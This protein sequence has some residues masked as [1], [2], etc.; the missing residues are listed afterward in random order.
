MSAGALKASSGYE[1]RPEGMSLPCMRIAYTEEDGGR[2]EW[3]HE[4]LA[5]IAWLEE[6]FPD[7]GGDWTGNIM[8]TTPLQRARTAE[9]L[10]LIAEA[11][12]YSNIALIHSNP[13]T[14]SWSGLTAAEM[15]PSAAAAASRRFHA[16]LAKFESWVEGD[17]LRGG[18]RSLSGEGAKV[19]VADVVLMCN[20][21]YM[22][23]SYGMDWVEEHGVLRVWVE[24]VKGEEG[25]GWFVGVG[26]LREA[27]GRGLGGVLGE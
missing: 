14:L 23:E 22:E 1:E 5:I 21:A 10:S 9:I 24:R 12:V 4:S 19:T 13:S 7:G 3:V 25:E 27:E 20:V 2:V 17:V 6:K 8:G 11:T 16:L 26:E 15:S 18:S